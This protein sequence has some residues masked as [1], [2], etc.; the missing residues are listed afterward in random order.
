MTHSLHR[1]GTEENLKN[2]YVFYVRGLK[3]KDCRPQL[4][5]IWEILSSEGPVNSRFM[6][7]ERN[8]AAAVDMKEVS[9]QL[10]DIRGFACVFSSKDKTKRVLKKL[11]EADL[12]LSIVVSGLIDEIT[13]M[14]REVGLKPHTANLSL[15][16][17]GRGKSLLPEDKVLEL[18]TMCGH[19]LVGSRLTEIVLDKV[20]AGEMAPKEASELIACQCPCGIFNLDRAEELLS[21]HKPKA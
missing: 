8:F 20:K 10:E 12:G 1:Y 5:K 6:A 17:H 7:E 21:L 15:G 18:T 3:V 11:K 9:R 2:D 14:A 13:Q 19:G 16:V 4:L